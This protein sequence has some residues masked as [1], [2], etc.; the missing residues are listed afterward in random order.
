MPDPSFRPSGTPSSWLAILLLAAW[1]ALSAAPAGSA[2]DT[3]T[4]SRTANLPATTTSAGPSPTTTSFPASPTT[5]TGGP[6]APTLA[7]PV[8]ATPAARSIPASFPASVT[9]PSVAP[10]PAPPAWETDVRAC[11]EAARQG[12][13]SA[14]CRL[15]YLLSVGAEGLPV[16]LP[17]ARQWYRAAAEQGDP[18]SIFRYALCITEGIGGSREAAEATE[19]IRWLKMAAEAGDPRAQVCW[20]RHIQG[21]EGKAAGFEAARHWFFKAITRGND[22]ALI[23]LGENLLIRANEP[24]PDYHWARLLF[25]EAARG[26]D[27]DGWYY[28]GLYE[29]KGWIH[30]PDRKAAIAFY[31]TAAAGGSGRAWGAL[32]SLAEEA[33]AVRAAIQAYEGAVRALVAS[34]SEGLPLAREARRRASLLRRREG[35]PPWDWNWPAMAILPSWLRRPPPTRAAVAAQVPSWR[36]LPGMAPENTPAYLLPPASPTVGP[37]TSSSSR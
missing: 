7:A 12:V 28:L 13:A 24:V 33:G 17:A 27:P 8:P 9:A 30:P 19:G 25:T 6:A 29:E 15:A 4:V 21:G 26:G 2:T 10:V 23:A 32:A 36:P 22:P 3:P 20:G 37:P 31:R 5:A 16:D 14:Q 35:L 34:G 11:E 1:A 18:E